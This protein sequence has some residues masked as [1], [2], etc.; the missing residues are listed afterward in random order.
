[1]KYESVQGTS[2][3]LVYI[4]IYHNFLILRK[5]AIEILAINIKFSTC[6]IVIICINII[7]SE[8]TAVTC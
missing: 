2:A 6:N 3:S 8:I 4:I 5:E 7:P 1:V